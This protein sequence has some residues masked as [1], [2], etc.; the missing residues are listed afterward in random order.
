MSAAPVEA[1]DILMPA[2]RRL[3]ESGVAS[4]ALDSRLI[5]G[6]ALGLD[7]AVLPHETLDCFENAAAVR[8]EG[9]LARRIGGE[10]ASL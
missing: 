7:R 6:M 3:E 5:L 2:V 8:F 10:P 1:R 4:P 9:L